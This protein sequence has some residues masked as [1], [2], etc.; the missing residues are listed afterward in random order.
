MECVFP[1]SLIKN[2]DR[3]VRP[4]SKTSIFVLIETAWMEMGEFS[5]R[6]LP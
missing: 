6:G 4:S 5:L 3:Y 2:A 1:V